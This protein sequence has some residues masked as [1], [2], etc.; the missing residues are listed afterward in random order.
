[1]TVVGVLF[2]VVWFGALLLAGYWSLLRVCFRIVV[3][4]GAVHWYAPARSGWVSLAEINGARAV[5]VNSSDG[6][7]SS[8][9][10][11]EFIHRSSGKPIVFAVTKWN[12][13][14][15]VDFLFDLHDLLPGSSVS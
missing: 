14:R 5:L 3:K 13:D 12:H 8:P 10:Y 6:I 1:V 11:L 7:G 9:L 2:S 15:A 4:D